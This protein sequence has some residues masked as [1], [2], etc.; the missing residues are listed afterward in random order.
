MSLAV[1]LGCQSYH[2]GVAE[3]ANGSASSSVGLNGGKVEKENRVVHPSLV[4]TRRCLSMR[5]L[6][7][8]AMS[9]PHNGLVRTLAGIGWLE[10]YIIDET[11]HDI[12]LVGRTSKNWPSL[13]L[14]D[15]VVNIRNVW[16]QDTFPVVSLDPQREDILR[17]NEIISQTRANISEEEM[18]RVSKK[19]RDAWGP[20]QVTVQGIPRNSRDAHIMIDADYHMKK[21]SQGLI[22]LNGISS[23][24][25]LAIEDARHQLELKGTLSAPGMSM[26]REWFHIGENEPTFIFDK[27][28]LLLEKCSVV[29]LTEQQRV[30]A[31]GTLSDS[32]TEDP[33]AKAFAKQVSTDFQ[34][35]A[36]VVPAYADLENLFRL[37]A[38][39]RGLHFR[40]DTEQAGMDFHSLWND[41]KYQS[42]SSMPLSM[43][44]LTNYKQEY[45]KTSK[46]DQVNQYR[47]FPMVFGGVSMD[48]PIGPAQ[49]RSNSIEDLVG[50]RQIV[51]EKRPTQTS[52]WWEMPAASLDNSMSKKN[53]PATNRPT[54][55][56]TPTQANVFFE[57]VRTGTPQQV[58]QA[59][60]VGADVNARDKEGETPL[61]VAAAHNGN[62]EV[63][64]NL[65]KAGADVNA[66]ESTFGAT[67]ILIAAGY[68]NLDVINVLLK[69]GADIN[70]KSSLG[71]TPLMFAAEFNT[72]PEVI[73]VLLKAGANAKV[74]QPS[75]KTALDF[76]LSNEKLKGSDAIRIL[77]AAT[78]PVQKKPD[79]ETGNSLLPQFDQ[80]LNGANPVRVQNP[81]DFAIEVGVRSGARGKNFRVAA[82]GIQTIYV[83]DGKYDIY[84]V[85]SNQPDALYQG[86]SFTLNRTGVEIKVVKAINGNYD[87]HR[88]K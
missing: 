58:Q 49:F 20:Q 4:E 27:G 51:I 78:G 25:D 11:N 43:P 85:Y 83:P 12:I 38:V 28:V 31:D 37:S 23:S 64:T 60:N 5:V 41:Y 36:C 73:N 82:Y 32:G 2:G 35:E 48:I 9:D 13:S 1:V 16:N 26:S 61:I 3:N 45:V 76:A 21:L 63:I 57:L 59:I 42:E 30:A 40:K 10:G 24:L 81:N 19:I 47:L 65:L 15:L 39:L 88:V 50:L 46:G 22:A 74:R 87:I 71:F 56:M 17:I 68:N 52:L 8:Q 80:E 55:V 86:D 67:A 84:F 18:L 6:A 62:P 72:N 53:Q 70:A 29:V 44:G 54:N 69:A 77:S 79:E 66:Q 14:D 7:E 33:Y 75:G 34:Q